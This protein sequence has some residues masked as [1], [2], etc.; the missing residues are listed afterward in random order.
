MKKL[1]LAALLGLIATGCQHPGPRFEPRE[2]PQVKRSI[3]DPPEVISPTKLSLQSV[4][5][6]NRFDQELL[7][8]SQELFTLGPGDR[9]EVELLDDLGSR[10]TTTV[11]PD[12]KLYF[13]LLPG[14]DVWGL[15]LTQA[16]EALEIEFAKFVK[17]PPQISLT[18]RDVSSKRVWLLGR[19]KAPG[20]YSLTNSTTLLDAVLQAGGPANFSGEKDLSVA[21][22]T[23]E[24]AD[25]Q[26]SFVIRKG[27]MIPVDFNRL[28]KQGDLSQNIYLEAD[29]FVYMPA[30]TSRNVYVMGAVSQPRAIAYSE[31]LTLAGAIAHAGGKIQYSYLSHVAIVRGSLSDPKI[32]IVDAKDILTGRA[33]DI[34]LQ[35]RDIVY[36]PLKPYRILSRYLDLIMT[37]FVSSVAINE[38]ARAVL[39][40]P[41][42]TSGILIPFGST[43]TVNPGTTAPAR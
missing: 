10:S 17:Q 16:K 13:N 24:L 36:V 2:K 21:N 43:I 26:R 35:P 22:N 29:D 27:K 4:A 7:K 8:P 11:G 3:Y 5:T 42:P 37:T 12:G 33:T 23:D 6:T 18:L 40:N 34:P 39:D 38:G 25:L 30:T 15:T 9:V 14:V 19:F 32:A 1:F 41:P 31:D 28:L 20:I